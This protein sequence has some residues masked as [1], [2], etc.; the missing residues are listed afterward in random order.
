MLEGRFHI[1]SWGF[2]CSRWLIDR[3]WN[4][5]LQFCDITNRRLLLVS[6]EFA[7]EFSDATF[8]EVLQE[9]LV[10]ERG[11]CDL[12]LRRYWRLNL[13]VESPANVMT[14]RYVNCRV[15]GRMPERKRCCR[16]S[17][18]VHIRA[19]YRRTLHGAE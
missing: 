15:R 5:L 7:N 4:I 16:L 13:M 1:T 14:L 11:R 12:Y 18:L 19:K 8:G 6:K 10:W 17:L 9:D 2:E 3:I